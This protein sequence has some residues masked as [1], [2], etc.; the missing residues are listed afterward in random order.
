MRRGVGTGGKPGKG[1]PLPREG[2]EVR[3]P[4]AGRSGAEGLR[5]EPEVRVRYPGPLPWAPEGRPAGV[6]EF[7][8]LM[9]E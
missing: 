8:L 6:A 9:F 2:E 4:P 5:R 7:D 1:R 3:R